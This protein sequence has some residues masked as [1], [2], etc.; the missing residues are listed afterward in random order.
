MLLANCEDARF[1]QVLNVS[2]KSTRKTRPQPLNTIEA[3]KLISRK[4]KISP[5]RS[6]EIM[7]S[8]YNKGF[9]S[10]PRTETNRYNKTITLKEIV[11]KLAHSNSWGQHAN[12]ILSGE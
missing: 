6:M 4:L 8:L 2:K 1:A 12:Q 7:E 9:L 5:A 11:E 10:Y 3:Q